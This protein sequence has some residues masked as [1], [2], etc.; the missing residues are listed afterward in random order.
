MEWEPAEYMKLNSKCKNP[1]FLFELKG[2]CILLIFTF[3][4]LLW[5]STN[6]CSMKITIYPDADGYIAEVVDQPNMFAFGMTPEEAR[7]ELRLVLDGMME[8]YLWKMQN[9]VSVSSS[10]D[11][12]AYAV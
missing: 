6:I 2:I 7:M 4:S 10:I 3:C 5:R 1:F 9:I 12:E 11:S 8:F